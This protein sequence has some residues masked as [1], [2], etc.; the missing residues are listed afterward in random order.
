MDIVLEPELDKTSVWD[1]YV[2]ILKQGNSYNVYLT[3][4]IEMPSNYNKLVH[5]INTAED[6]EVINLYISNGGGIVDSAFYIIDAIKH[7]KALVV[8]H[9]SATVASA[10]TIIALSCDEIITSKYLSFMVHNYSTGM[11]GKG[12]ELKAYQNFSDREL[13]R[14]FKEIYSGFL[15]DDEMNKVIEGA[16]IWLNEDEVEE[17]WERKSQL[18]PTV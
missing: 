13:N 9:L 8:G 18:T 3:D 15:T 5:L 16:D 4:T 6:F 11:Q 17:R 7:S 10:A 1:D 14:A 2:P 12:H